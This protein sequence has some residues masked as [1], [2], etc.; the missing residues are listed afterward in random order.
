MSQGYVFSKFNLEVRILFATT[1]HASQVGQKAQY[2]SHPPYRYTTHNSSQQLVKPT[3]FNN[4]RYT[5][6]IPTDPCTVTTANIKTNMRNIHTSMSLST[7]LQET[8]IKY[9]SHTHRKSATLKNLPRNTRRTLAQLSTN[10]SLFLLSYLH[11]IDASTHTSRFCLFVAF[12]SI[13]HHISSVAHRY[14]LRCRPWI[15]GWIPLA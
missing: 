3:T 9:C 10:R 13:L 1:V 11:K 15:C 6:N 5:T 14:T 4:S 8:I 12:A 7:L 2:P